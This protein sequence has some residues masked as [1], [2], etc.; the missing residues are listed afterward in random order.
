MKIIPLPDLSSYGKVRVY[1]NLR[2]KKLSVMCT[3]TRKVIGHTDQ[4]DLLE[5]KFIVSKKGVER[6]RKHKRKVVCA[7][8]EG[9]VTKFES[10]E[11]QSAVLFNPHLWDSFVNSHGFPIY[12]ASKVLIYSS[13]WIWADNLTYPA[14]K[15]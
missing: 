6:I 5:A 15:V 9:Y 13:G 1:R 3:T 4:I 11:C 7:F 8:V 12:G 14:Y 10:D 2:N